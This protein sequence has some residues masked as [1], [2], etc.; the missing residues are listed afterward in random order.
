MKFFFTLSVLLSAI[1]LQASPLDTPMALPSESTIS[2]VLE[3]IVQVTGLSVIYIKTSPD[4]KISSPPSDQ[5]VKKVLNAICGEHL[6][7]SK[8]GKVLIVKE[9]NFSAPTLL[10]K[11][12]FPASTSTEEDKTAI[13][14]DFLRMKLLLFGDSAFHWL[15][16]P[17]QLAGRKTILERLTHWANTNTYPTYTIIA[18]CD[19]K[20]SKTIY[21]DIILIAETKN[22]KYRHALYDPKALFWSIST[23]R[24]EHDPKKIPFIGEDVLDGNKLLSCRLSLLDDQRFS[25]TLKNLSS[26]VLS[27]KDFKQGDLLLNDLASTGKF[28]EVN[29]IATYFVYPP[30][31]ADLPDEFQLAPGEERTFVFPLQGCRSRRNRDRQIWEIGFEKKYPYRPGKDIEVLQRRNRGYNLYG[32]V[33]YFYGPDGKK[34]K[35]W[36]RSFIDSTGWPE[37]QNQK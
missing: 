11:Y 12:Q 14:I 7:W 33:V 17:S 20:Q 9:K 32:I 30:E 1:M 28:F 5:S 3:E 13:D 18:R 36:N 26:Q 16:G 31:K 2:Q 15:G 29:E 23:I 24:L 6:T 34:Y 25:V 10:N 8:S 22:P 4:I 19:A 21:D 37:P 35:S 27:L